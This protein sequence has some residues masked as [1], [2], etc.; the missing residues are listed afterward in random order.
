[1]RAATE[2][3]PERFAKTEKRRAWTSFFFYCESRVSFRRLRAER[4]EMNLFYVLAGLLLP[5]AIG[6]ITRAL[7]RPVK[8]AFSTKAQ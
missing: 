2:N 3:P 8:A 1:M 5:L 6:A 4:I 7:L